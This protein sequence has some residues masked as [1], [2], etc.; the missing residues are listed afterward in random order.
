[1]KFKKFTASVLIFACIATM[2]FCL[3]HAHA[4]SGQNEHVLEIKAGRLCNFQQVQTL[5]DNY[6]STR[7]DVLL[8]EEKASLLSSRLAENV[9]DTT[10][11]KR[12][13]QRTEAKSNLMKYH[14]VHTLEATNSAI[15]RSITPFA[16]SAQDTFQLDVYEWT[17]LTYNDGKGSDSD[18]M[19]YATEHLIIV[20]ADEEDNYKIIEDVYDEHEILGAQPERTEDPTSDVPFEEDENNHP[21][22]RNGVNS[23]SNIAYAVN[24]VVDYADNWV[25][26]QYSPDNSMQN[27]GNYN[28]TTYGYYSADCANFVS[29]CM[30]AG[31]MVWDYGSGKD[32]GNWDGTQWWFD[33]NP[34]PNYENYLVSPNSWRYVP[35]FIL[36]WENQG[37]SKVFATSSNVYPGNPV[38]NN[39]SHVGIC[40]G[41]NSSGTPIV[42]A[43]NR[44][45]YHVPYT[46]I[47]SGTLRTI[48][49][50]TSNKMVN[51]PENATVIS[52]T[53]TNQTTSQR[54]LSSGAN[55]Y[56]K[57]TVTSSG[58]YTFESSYYN[59]TT[60]DTR[61]YLYRESKTSNGQTLY[62]YEIAADDDG[63]TGLNFKI[64]KYLSP[65]TYYLRVRAYSQTATGSYYLNYK[66][67]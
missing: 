29:Q 17:W 15:V 58:Y 24:S 41:Y 65:G 37:Y 4:L 39:E 19:G 61:A 16:G 1:M 13:L 36:Y 6:F 33:I 63:G 59:N 11:L 8:A 49:I 7:R 53:T 20:A 2:C 3:P 18:T 35:K 27:P 30:R 62:M 42:N 38:V 23:S 60:F 48:K 10:T 44:D 57:I 14:N 52:P 46:M 50:T 47:G 21:L 9:S 34:D 5:L 56:Y 55:H 40:V 67:G 22:Q 54:Y 31:G 64:R 51:T 32:N 45:V 25:I 12:E 43:H 28:T 26:H 66:K